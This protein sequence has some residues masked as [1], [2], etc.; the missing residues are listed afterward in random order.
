MLH[1]TINNLDL[2]KKE[3]ESKISKLNYSN[4]NPKIIAICKTFPST[5]KGA[6][7]LTFI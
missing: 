2:I 6:T 5:L 7:K 4:Y 3:I 1:K